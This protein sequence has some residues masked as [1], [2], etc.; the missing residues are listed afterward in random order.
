MSLHMITGAQYIYHLLFLSFF[1]QVA[2]IQEPNKSQLGY[3]H[4][5]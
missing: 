5:L 4:I 3:H 1:L 2:E